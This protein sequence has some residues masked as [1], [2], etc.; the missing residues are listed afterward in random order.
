MTIQELLDLNILE[1]F[2][3]DKLSEREKQE[4]LQKA[5]SLILDRVVARISKELPE[6][7]RQQFF[8]IFKEGVSD[9]ER[10]KFIQEDIP[11]LESVILEELLAFKQEAVELTTHNQRPTTKA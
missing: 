6:D 11:D 1:I 3:L 2:G 9:E 7:K 10:W 5:V 8:E 4:F